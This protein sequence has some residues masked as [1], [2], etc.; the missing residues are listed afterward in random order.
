MIKR[1]EFKIREF[2]K[3]ELPAKREEK[4]KKIRSENN[5]KREGDKKLLEEKKNK[6]ASMRYRE[7]NTIRRNEK[8]F[9]KK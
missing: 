9:G 3:K 1:G 4:L 6:I 8:G 2:N 5:D 7:K